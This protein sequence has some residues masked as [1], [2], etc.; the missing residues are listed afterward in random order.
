MKTLKLCPFCGSRATITKSIHPGYPKGIYT[1]QCRRCPVTIDKNYKSKTILLKAWN[2]RESND[3]LI[4]ALECA[5]FSIKN[6]LTCGEG[7]VPRTQQDMLLSLI[8]Q[9]LVGE[10]NKKSDK[11]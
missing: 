5:F 1:I 2:R 11:P 7:D 6:R 9:A 3:K 4:E 8:E 10:T